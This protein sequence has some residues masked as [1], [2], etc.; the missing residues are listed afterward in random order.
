M[1]K[2]LLIVSV[3]LAILVSGCTALT[4][5]NSIV[6]SGRPASRDYAI[7]DFNAVDINSAFKV[8]IVRGDAFKVTVTVDDNMLDYVQ[9]T[10]EGNTLRISRNRGNMTSFSAKIGEASIIMP[11][12]QS[13]RLN[14]AS[15]GTMTGFGQVSKFDGDLNG[16]SRLSGDVQAATIT[17]SA[18]GASQYSLKGKGASLTLDQNGASKADL[19]MLAVQQASVTLSGASQA[20]VNASSSLGYDLNGASTLRYAGS[21]IVGQAR[22]EGASTARHE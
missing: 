22:A 17:L 16:A 11:E 9:V 2:I 12:L 3:F 13:V 1:Y 5:I 14:G 20:S 21:P 6:G 19:S 15:Q 8:S 10:K 7:R 18:N 4:S